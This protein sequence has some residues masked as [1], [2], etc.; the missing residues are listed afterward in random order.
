[1]SGIM[2]FCFARSARRV[3]YWGFGRCLLEQEFLSLP[4]L[5]LATGG[6]GAVL[7]SLDKGAAD[8]S[9]EGFFGSRKLTLY[10]GSSVRGKGGLNVNGNFSGFLKG[11][12][13]F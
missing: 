4:V 5:G 2:G 3:L 12:K 11:F 10:L 9:V 1:M 8:V 13:T 6:A 7:A